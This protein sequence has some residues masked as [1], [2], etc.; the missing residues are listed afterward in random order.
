MR[1]DIWSEHPEYV[2]NLKMLRASG[3]PA[4]RIAME[5]NLKFGTD[6]TRNA[7]IGKMGRLGLPKPKRDARHTMKRP[8]NPVPHETKRLDP[9]RAA[10]LEAAMH[11]V[12]QIKQA[13]ELPPDQS[14]FAVPFRKLN[15]DHCRW[16]IDQPSGPIWYC[17]AQKSVQSYCWRH[18]A[19]GF[20][21]VSRR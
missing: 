6:F 15:D 1:T 7:I 10:H 3:T 18:A 17:G 2:N 4:S 19:I 16:P 8:A 9:F 11:T 5:M 13:T 12:P 20:R 21:P 14:E